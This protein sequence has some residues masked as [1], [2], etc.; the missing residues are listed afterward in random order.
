MYSE[1]LG[2]GK[3]RLGH[4][5]YYR[6]PKR[7]RLHE[8]TFRPRLLAGGKKGGVCCRFGEQSKGF[9]FAHDECGVS[10]RCLSGVLSGQ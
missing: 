1:A 9:R 10:A 3:L 6:G 5:L 8:Q 4:S 7:A 2:Q